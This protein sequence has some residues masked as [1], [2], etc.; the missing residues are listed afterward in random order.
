[1]SLGPRGVDQNYGKSTLH[2][3]NQTNQHHPLINSTNPPPNVPYPPPPEIARPYENRAYEILWVSVVIHSES[4]NPP[5][6]ALVASILWPPERHFGEN[7]GNRGPGNSPGIFTGIMKCQPILG[8]NHFQAVNI[9]WFYVILM[10]F[11]CFIVHCLD[12]NFTGIFWV[13]TSLKQVDGWNL[14]LTFCSWLKPWTMLLPK[15]RYDLDGGFN[16]F[17]EISP[18]FSGVSWHHEMGGFNHQLV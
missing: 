7:L 14:T 3:A 5:G 6:T 16:H 8:G 13:G 15:H 1:M 12:G 10:D 2:Q 17:W 18:L 4:T 9:W 11:L